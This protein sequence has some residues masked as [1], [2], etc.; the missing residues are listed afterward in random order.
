VVKRDGLTF[1]LD[2]VKPVWVNASEF[3]ITGWVVPAHASEPISIVAVVDGTEIPGHYGLPRPDVGRHFA[4]ARLA[5][6]GFVVRVT[7][8][9]DPEPITVIARHGERETVLAIIP[10]SEARKNAAVHGDSYQDWIRSYEPRLFIPRSNVAQFVRDLEYQPLISI[11]L[12]THNTPTFFLQR[13]VESVLKQHYCNWQ[14]CVSDDKSTDEKTLRVLGAYSQ[15]HPRIEVIRCS[16]QRGISGASNVA[17]QNARGEYIVLLDHDDELHP[18]A[19]LEVVRAL[20]KRR[21]CRLLYSD[22]DKIDHYGVRSQPAFKPDFDSNIFLSF[23]YLGHL[24]SL[25]RALAVSV[26]GFRPETDGAQDWDLLIRAVEQIPTSAIWHIPK[27]LYHWRMHEKSTSANLDAKPYVAAAW[28]RV[29]KDHAQRTSKL[30]SVLPGLFYGSMR[31][32]YTAPEGT[33]VGVFLRHEDGAFQSNVVRCTNSTAQIYSVVGTD[34]IREE[35]G[36]H[37]PVTRS[38]GVQSD[39]CVF[40]NGSLESLSHLFFEELVA[41]AMRPDCGLATGMAIDTQNTTLPTA[42]VHDN[43][44]LLV[45]YYAGLRIPDHGYMGLVS[46]VR[47]VAGCSPLMF[48]TRRE[49]LMAVGGLGAISSF[50]MRRLSTALAQHARLNGLSVVYT[51]YAVASFS[52]STTEDSQHRASFGDGNLARVNPN[53]APL[54]HVLFPHTQTRTAHTCSC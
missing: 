26:G 40:L 43:E 23:N 9:E 14:L 34:V 25:D 39:V 20:N 10:Q 32:K 49:H 36:G 42:Y 52:G 44:D 31:L 17:L 3:L 21:N 11:I 7:A 27:P 22:E 48:A 6:C 50:D 47:S 15:L 29:L 51:P 5:N 16:S 1:C 45:D 41:Q 24:I 4:D 54:S 33:Q 46:V 28:H 37:S 38:D 19:L 35:A 13:C 18:A 12:P 8:S 2:G 30:V 53:L